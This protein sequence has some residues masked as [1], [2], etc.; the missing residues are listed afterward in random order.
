MLKKQK[1]KWVQLSKLN[2]C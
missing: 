1:N 2:K